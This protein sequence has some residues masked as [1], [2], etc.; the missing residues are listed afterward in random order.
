MFLV[1]PSLETQ[2]NTY[3]RE[4]KKYPTMKTNPSPFHP[5]ILKFPV[6]VPVAARLHEQN[7][8]NGSCPFP[9]PSILLEIHSN[10]VHE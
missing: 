1:S 2:L 10:M 8:S 7:T 9:I 3:G 6:Q 5:V 4:R